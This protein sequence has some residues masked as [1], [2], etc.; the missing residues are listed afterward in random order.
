MRFYLRLR[1]SKPNIISF[2][3]LLLIS[4]NETTSNQK[5]THSLNYDRNIRDSHPQYIERNTFSYF[6]YAKT[7]SKR[8]KENRNT[9]N[10]SLYP[11]TDT[12]LYICIYLYIVKNMQLKKKK[13]K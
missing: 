8:K 1:R 4:L 3:F 2:L 13:Q 11:M 9:Q 7:K 10:V 12:L 6:K 5:Q